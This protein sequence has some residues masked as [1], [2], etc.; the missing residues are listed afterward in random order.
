MLGFKTSYDAF[1]VASGA[2]REIV[3]GRVTRLPVF[4][5]LDRYVTAYPAITGA[6]LP[7]PQTS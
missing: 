5:T 2:R 4:Q 7:G 6:G 1:G 3:L